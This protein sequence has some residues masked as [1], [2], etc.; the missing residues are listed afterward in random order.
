ME[1]QTTQ[2]V[3][4]HPEKKSSVNQSISAAKLRCS[5][6]SANAA[7]A[8]NAGN[9]SNNDLSAEPVVNV[10]ATATL[11]NHMGSAKWRLVEPP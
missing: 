3:S 9:A 1:I 10:A 11:A 7:K 8:A 4:A 5:V 6:G 2:I